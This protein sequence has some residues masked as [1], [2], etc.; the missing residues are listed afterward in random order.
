MGAFI[1]GDRITAIL[2]EDVL[3][4]HPGALILADIKSSRACLDHIAGFGGKPELTRTGH[5]FIKT[6][7]VETGALMAGEM[8]GHVF[9]ADENYGYDDGL[10]AALRLIR[11]LNET[12]KSLHA[13]NAFPYY[14]ATPEVRIP[15]EGQRKFEIV[16]EMKRLLT[17]GKFSYRDDDGVRVE[18]EDGFWLLRASNTADYLIFR[19]EGVDEEA[20]QRQKDM[21]K[22]MYGEISSKAERS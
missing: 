9:F 3:K 14:P 10:Y 13:L 19:A 17:I 18:N 5:S 6:K 1:E 16:E 8:S 4:K 21:F 11:L 2:A 20:L 12:Q 7:L 15:C 22:H